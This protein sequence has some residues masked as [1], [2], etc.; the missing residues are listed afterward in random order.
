M[1]KEKLIT[2][3]QVKKEIK[4]MRLSDMETIIYQLQRKVT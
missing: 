3:A 4:N 1:P 2:I